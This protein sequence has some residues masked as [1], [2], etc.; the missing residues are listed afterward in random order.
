MIKFFSLLPRHGRHLFATVPIFSLILLAALL[1]NTGEAQAQRWPLERGYTYLRLGLNG[2]HGDQY[3]GSNGSEVQ[4][5]RLEENTWR[6]YSEYGYSRYVTGIVSVPAY[7]T[8]LVQENAEA[9]V[10]RVESP[11]DIELGLRIGIF[12]GENDVILLAGYFGIPLGE[13]ANRNGLWSGDD[14]YDQTVMLG[15][16]HYFERFAAR[17]SVQ[18]GY[19]FRNDGYSDEVLVNGDVELRPLDFLEFVLRVRY[20]QSQGNGDP[21]F[22]GGRYGFASNHRRFL[23]YGPEVALWITRDFGVSASVYATTDA[24][25]MPAATLF[26]AGFF[27]LVAPSGMQ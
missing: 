10:Q 19:H 7:R 5:Q 8:L 15:Y 26:S 6:F 14:E 2:F 11:G 23:M 13:T 27:L 4:V 20:L 21:T 16:G 18:G 22:A 24:R 3:Y 17:L 25:N 1:L 12:P 9:P